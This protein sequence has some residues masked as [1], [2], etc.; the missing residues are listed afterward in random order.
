M[1]NR[2]EF[3]DFLVVAEY[4]NFSKA[5]DYLGC[6]QSGLSKSIK[7]L[8]QEVG[9]TLFIRGARKLVLTDAGKVFLKH[10]NDITHLSS[11]C[12]TEINSLD[13][14]ASGS[15]HFACHNIFATYLL[16]T[17]LKKLTKYPAISISTEF[18]SSKASVELVNDLSADL[19]IAINPTKYLDLVIT[20]LWKEFIGLYSIDGKEKEHILYNEEM[21]TAF[22]TLAE[23]ENTSKTNI[24]D[25]KVINSILKRNNDFMGLL[26]SPIA[27][28]SKKLKL[29][30][31]IS[32][33]MNVSL[34]YRSDRPRS[35]GFS[36]L[37][38]VIK[39][40]KR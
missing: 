28:N 10:L 12:L 8:E 20:P 1:K 23:F 40:F 35:R 22:S 38:D 34:V 30:K 29:V 31:K 16:P 25:Y 39:S 7:R 3:T 9:A 27:E 15:F 5:A 13:T 2:K 36:Y 11:K 32:K 21:I 4:E 6:K 19:C 24:N 26:P 33:D 14:I 18:C 17:V 37:V